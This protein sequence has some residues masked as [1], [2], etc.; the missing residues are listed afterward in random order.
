MTAAKE[1]TVG[2]QRR[3][4]WRLD[5]GVPRGVDQLLLAARA[6]HEPVRLPLADLGARELTTLHGVDAQLAEGAAALPAQGPAF[7][8]WRLT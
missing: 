5:H 1:A 8:V 3:R 4:V 7:H 2:R 6:E